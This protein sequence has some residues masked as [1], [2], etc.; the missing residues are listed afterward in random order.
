[1][2][3]RRAFASAR[4]E[5][6]H[7]PPEVPTSRRSPIVPAGGAQPW[8]VV[9]PRLDVQ[10][11]TRDPDI[12]DPEIAQLRVDISVRCPGHQTYDKII[13]LLTA[14]APTPEREAT[15]GIAQ[16]R[17]RSSAMTE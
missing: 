3:D 14:P 1:M 7:A 13:D 17:R 6:P 10:A 16:P 12:A 2:K 5:A 8:G 15:I 4:R 9:D 11:R